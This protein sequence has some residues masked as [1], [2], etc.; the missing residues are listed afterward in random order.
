MP[1]DLRFAE[2][3]MPEALRAQFAGDPFDAVMR[4]QGKIFR[5]VPGRK[6]VQVNLGGASYF[7]KQHFGV[8]WAEVL[9]NLTSLRL[10]IF[11]AKTEWQAIRRFGEIGIPTTPAVA[12]GQRGLNPASRQSFLITADLGDIVS[13]ED[14]C[15][16]WPVTAPPLALKRQII[17]EIARIAGTLH[18][19][20]MNHR[21]FYLCH[22]CLDRAALAQSRVVLYLID[23]HRVGMRKRISETARMKDLAALLF[24]VKDLGLSHRD[25]LRFLSGYLRQSAGEER[26]NV[27]AF[28]RSVSDRADQLY[29]KYQRIGPR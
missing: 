20:G 4:L 13:L 18:A 6:T 29:L 23:L 7:V 24:S 27:P 19:H 3:E 17:D 11:S 28:W 2:L 1:P 21:D 8:G 25:L 5:D 10:P 14:F 22:F 16:D 9:K 15:R 26:F 12:Y